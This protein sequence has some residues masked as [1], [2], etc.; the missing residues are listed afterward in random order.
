MHLCL[1]V[2]P[3][4]MCAHTMPPNAVAYCRSKKRDRFYQAVSKDI[5][6]TVLIWCEQDATQ[7]ELC[8]T[9]NN[10]SIR[11]YAHNYICTTKQQRTRWHQT[12]IKCADT[13]LVNWID[14]CTTV[15]EQL[16]TCCLSIPCCT[17]QRCVTNLKEK[18]KLL[19][20]Q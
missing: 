7:D 11:S 4:L 15:K 9:I 8:C 12:E 10:T 19:D 5:S 16:H 6:V 20:C 1:G 14:R 17:M 13:H 2:T 18:C 3:H